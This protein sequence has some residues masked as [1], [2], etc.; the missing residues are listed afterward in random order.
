[1]Y[2]VAPTG[3]FNK[4]EEKSEMVI[5]EGKTANNAN[6][7]LQ[8]HGVEPD[9]LTKKQIQE[10]LKLLKDEQIN[11][12]YNA[13]LT[14][15]YKYLREVELGFAEPGNPPK[16]PEGIDERLRAENLILIHNLGE[17]L[18]KGHITL[19]E[20]LEQ[21]ELGLV[22]NNPDNVTDV[23]YKQNLDTI[24]A[25]ANIDR[26]E[27]LRR[28]DVGKSSSGVD[29]ELLVK[30]CM[31]SKGN[32][33]NNLIS[34]VEDLRLKGISDKAILNYISRLKDENGVISND[35][36]QKLDDF[37]KNFSAKGSLNSDVL[38]LF[39][40]ITT[41]D[42]TQIIKFPLQNK[43]IT[44]III[45]VFFIIFNYYSQYRECKNIDYK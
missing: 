44:E 29:A 9:D 39:S 18:K 23:S 10:H 26:H 7:L 21:Y 31:D 25:D 43:I 42:G 45:S 3:I 19:D 33:K 1:M 17:G 5:L 22:R 20:A 41:K 4:I 40:A 30:T 15:H 35:I 14:A 38:T 13:Y 27:A 37:V 24:K 2:E 6:K 11:D 34:L 12:E 36:A 16:L 28:L 32:I 8:M